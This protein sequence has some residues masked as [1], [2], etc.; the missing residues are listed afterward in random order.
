M[1]L[2]QKFLY[3]TVPHTTPNGETLHHGHTREGTYV[4]GRNVAPQTYLCIFPFLFS[5]FVPLSLFVE[6][7]VILFSHPL[8]SLFRFGSFNV[9]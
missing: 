5:N 3:P 9:G 6:G 4:P 7:G 1:H 8:F 2:W